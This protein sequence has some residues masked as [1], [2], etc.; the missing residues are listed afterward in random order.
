M[1]MQIAFS[2][3]HHVLSKD[4]INRRT[5]LSETAKLCYLKKLVV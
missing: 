2:Y 4:Y 5:E 1:P 3:F